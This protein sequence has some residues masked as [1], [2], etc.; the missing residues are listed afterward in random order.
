[1]SLLN[2]MYTVSTE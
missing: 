2:T 1:M